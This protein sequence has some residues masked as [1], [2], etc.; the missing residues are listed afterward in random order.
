M[1]PFVGALALLAVLAL[2][3][4]GERVFERGRKRRTA[5]KQLRKP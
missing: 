4:L 5:S 2:L 3:V 1:L